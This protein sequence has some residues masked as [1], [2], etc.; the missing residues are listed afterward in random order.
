MSKLFYINLAVILFL[1]GYFYR[2]F[3]IKKNIK[4]I[5][6][7]RSSHQ[8]PVV[9]GGGIIFFSAILF[10]GI[11]ELYRYGFNAKFLAFFIG[12]LLLGILGF[13][14]DLKELT[15][16][17]RFPFQLISILLIL[18][19]SGLYEADMP[20]WVKLLAIIVSLGF[21]NAYNFMDGINGI[22]G[23][24]SIIVVITYWYL[25]AIYHLL[26]DYLFPLLFISL[27]VFGFFNYRKNALMFAG[28]IGSMSLAAVILF[29]LTKYMVELKSPVLILTV[30]LYGVDSAMTIILRFFNK[31]N[32]FKAHRWHVYQKM[33][34]VYHFSHL[35]TSFLYAITQAFI[36]GLLIHYAL[37]QKNL[38]FQVILLGIVLLIFV[39]LYL[40]IQREKL[41]KIVK[42]NK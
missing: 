35:K 5:P 29:I 20:V 11:Y 33:V 36:N 32:V 22:T 13:T 9:R 2:K 21:V 12:F 17:Q 34:D 28:D 25:N 41:F 14:D 1:I 40:L 4:D 23:F 38:K 10:F 42:S 3:A 27:M 19:A 30:L 16:K 24:Y 31:E 7:E 15:P 39:I 26:P 18:Y 6:S 37:Y 8:I